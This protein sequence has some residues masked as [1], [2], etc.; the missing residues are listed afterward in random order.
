MGVYSYHEEIHVPQKKQC[1]IYV[2]KLNKNEWCWRLIKVY[3]SSPLGE[4]WKTNKT[5]QLHNVLYYHLHIISLFLA[6]P[7]EQISHLD[8]L[9]CT[10]H[11]HILTCWLVS[12]ML[13]SL[14]SYSAEKDD[15]PL[16]RMLDMYRQPWDNLRDG[17]LCS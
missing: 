7:H 9:L 16:W 4:I 5:K 13:S 14:P 15:G 12:H 2:K 11:C 1:M 17:D 8:S 3:S 10:P 6:I